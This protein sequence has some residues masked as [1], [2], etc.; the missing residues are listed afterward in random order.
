MFPAQRPLIR[1]ILCFPN[2]PLLKAQDD[3]LSD[4]TFATCSSR[5]SEDTCP[6]NSK[7]WEFWMRSDKRL[8]DHTWLCCC[9]RRRKTCPHSISDNDF[10][11]WFMQEK[12]FFKIWLRVL[13]RKIK[14]FKIFHNYRTSSRDLVFWIVVKKRGG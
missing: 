2:K 8:W 1:W 10:H 5:Y 3:L 4:H 9:S 12:S 11:S 6:A 7:R 13:R 14:C